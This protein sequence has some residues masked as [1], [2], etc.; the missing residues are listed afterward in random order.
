[1]ASSQ[2]NPLN[3]AQSYEI[4]PPTT[5]NNYDTEQVSY[6]HRRGRV[7]LKG[8]R[9]EIIYTHLRDVSSVNS[10]SR[11]P[12]R[13]PL[14][15]PTVK[16]RF[17]IWDLLVVGLSFICLALAIT[18]VANE[19]VSWHLGVQNYQLVVLGL[20]LSI[21]N[22]CL[23]SVAP[24]LFLLLEARFGPSTLQNYDGIL[25]NQLLRSQLSVVWRLV[26]GLM[27]ALP[28][29]LSVAYKGFTCGESVMSVN[30]TT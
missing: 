5:V 27:L 19:S 11:K 10:S 12:S 15:K 13:P 24:T 22:L 6:S 14:G 8:D 2:G 25:R 3:N 7:H 9:E 18:A 21:M 29:A 28:L 16:K 20:L 1:M 4:Y 17:H 23:R 26:L 30:G